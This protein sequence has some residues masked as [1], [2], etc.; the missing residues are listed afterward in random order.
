MTEKIRAMIMEIRASGRC[1]ML[2][3]PMVQRLA[4]DRGY[5]EL[6]CWLEEHRKEYV[7]IR[8]LYAG[9]TGRNRQIQCSLPLMEK[10]EKCVRIHEAFS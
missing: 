5:Y 7:L 1:N 10:D 9:K 6:V 2:D 4:Y 8:T 3:L